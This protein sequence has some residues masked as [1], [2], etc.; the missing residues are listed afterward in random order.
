MTGAPALS[1]I[2]PKR[3]APA[4]APATLT[5]GLRAMKVERLWKEGA[6][7][8]GVRVGHLDTGVDGTHPALRGAV[9]RF[10]EFDDLGGLVRPTPRPYDTEDH[11]TH[12]A[13]TIA[14]ALRSKRWLDEKYATCFWLS[15]AP[16]ESAS[17]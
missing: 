14:S 3:R 16:T 4:H 12:T 9:E 11:G 8:K 5:W 13:G 2:Q 15:C 6:T 17:A 7:G 1:L 10:A